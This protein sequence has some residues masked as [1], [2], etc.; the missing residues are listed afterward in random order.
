MATTPKLGC[1]HLCPDRCST[2]STSTTL[3]G[4]NLQI[5]PPHVGYH[6]YEG[7]FATIG[8]DLSDLGIMPSRQPELG[9]CP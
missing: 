1:V 8:E 6:S 5:V 3:P 4:R 2:A 7:P 9:P